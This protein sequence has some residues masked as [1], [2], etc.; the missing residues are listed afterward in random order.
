MDPVGK[1]LWFIES[2]FAREIT[3]DEIATVG[4]VS[5]F[6]LS[7][8]FGMSTGHSVMRY[9]RGR[10]LTE[11]ARSLA[12]GA[13]DI[14]A[15]ALEASYGSHEAFTRAFR[16]QFGL[17]PETVRAQR[18][19]DNLA[20]VEAITM[21]QKLDTKLEP[22]RFE[23]GKT[24]LI[25]GISERYSYETC[26]RIPLQWQRFA[27]HIGHVPGQVGSTAYGVC[28]NMDDAGNIEYLAG[29][30]VSSFDGLPAELSRIRIPARRYAVFRH[31]GHIS[32]IRGTFH[33][34]WS[35]WLPESGHEAADAPDFERYTGAF[36]PDSGAGTVEIWVP[37]KA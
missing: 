32:A 8:A 15:V 4:G 19:L 24:L 7:R 11:A 31:C 29:V 6:H 20:L 5:R 14:L 1:A 12:A 2:H 35:K 37:L 3:L 17:T 26:Q 27:P 33:A 30:E 36:D 23:N 10:R 16:D 28:S 21:D 25:A 13:P 18:H 34:I 22:P 9:V